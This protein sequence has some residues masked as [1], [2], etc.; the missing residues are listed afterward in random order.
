MED[1]LLIESCPSFIVLPIDDEHS[2][3]YNSI[4]HIACKLTKIELLILDLYYK[5]QDREYILEQFPEDKKGLILK[6]LEFVDKNELLCTK[7]KE[8][9]IN[10]CVYLST[11]YLHLTYQCQLRCTYCYNQKIRK[12][13]KYKSLSKDE[14]IEIL[15]KILPYAN[16]IILTGG[17]CFLNPNIA[18]IVEYIKDVNPAIAISC[19]SNGMH[20]Y[21]SDI[22]NRVF[23]CIDSITLSCDSIS[24]VG[25][26]I[27]FNPELFK[28]NVLYIRTKYP[29]VKVSVATTITKN[30][31]ALNGEIKKFCYTNG[32]NLNNTVV[33]PSSLDE[34][35]L[36]PSLSEVIE[37]GA[38]A[39][40]A[41]PIKHL[42]QKR[43]RCSA[44][45]E[46]CSIDPMGNVY[47]CQSLHHQEFLLGN[48]M[49]QNLDDLK[50]IH[51]SEFC[52]PTVN[53]LEVCSSCK[54]KYMCGGGCIA[55]GYELYGGK[56]QRNH[57]TCALNHEN[58][59][60]KLKSLNNRID[61]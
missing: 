54:V 2:V 32:C 1:K 46:V 19:I 48:I 12:E 23:H 4:V 30:S 14:W 51:K 11:Y 27:G 15:D 40:E 39:H 24:S 56:L 6:S 58:A 61:E 13:Q 16:H 34:I 8:C 18:N 43:I 17:E 25:N 47:P 41:D 7:E 44:A 49:E 10:D 21:S 35:D 52:L 42:N 33:I 37:L 57:L 28:R 55:T 59:I 36:V 29:N 3:F 31:I 53:E 20:D 60:E 26:R 9:F 50:F 45:K 22:I 38:R 5:Y